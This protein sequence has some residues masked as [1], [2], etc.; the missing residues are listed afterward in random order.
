MQVGLYLDFGGI[1]ILPA[2]STFTV[3]DLA[4][5]TVDT[6]LPAGGAY[7]VELNVALTGSGFVDFGGARCQFGTFVGN[8]ATVWSDSEVESVDGN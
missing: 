3:I 4:S 8:P 6:A 2:L 7:N 5:M 1:R